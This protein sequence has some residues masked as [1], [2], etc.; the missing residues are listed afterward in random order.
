MTSLFEERERAAEYG[1]THGEELRFLALREGIESMAHWAAEAIGQPPEAGAGYAAALLGRLTGGAGVPDLVA[2]V[3]QDLEAAGHP[4][5]AREIPA[6]FSQAIATADD[7]LHGRLPPHHEAAAPPA[8]K[9]V[10][11]THGF[12]GWTV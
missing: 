5:L 7:R 3:S 1:Y 11:H 12:W 2:R 6:R 4:D 10:P 8:V 9:P